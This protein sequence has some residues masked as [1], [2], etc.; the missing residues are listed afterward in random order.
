MRSTT[1]VSSRRYWPTTG[2]TNETSVPVGHGYRAALDAATAS[3]PNV[4]AY[5]VHSQSPPMLPVLFAGGM[6]ALMCLRG[7]VRDEE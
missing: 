5:C 6:I 1:L 7:R 2:P 4:A 3:A